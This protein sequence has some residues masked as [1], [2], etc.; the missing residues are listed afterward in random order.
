[1]SLALLEKGYYHRNS[2]NTS[3]INPKVYSTLYRVMSIFLCFS[4]IL[5]L[6]S[7][8]FYMGD[9]TN[10]CDKIDCLLLLEFIGSLSL[11]YLVIF[12]FMWCHC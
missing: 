4:F 8:I 12:S 7:L 1:M 6:L 10:I 9:F 3:L 5:T 2:C 11:L